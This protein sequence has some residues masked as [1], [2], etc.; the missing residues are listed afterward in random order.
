[1]DNVAVPHWTA[2]PLY[3]AAKNAA[4][5][6]TITQVDFARNISHPWMAPR[7]FYGQ[8]TNYAVRD[9]DTCSI[10]DGS[11][12][13]CGHATLAAVAETTPL[14]EMFDLYRYETAVPAQYAA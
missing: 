13:N 7:S 10:I 9:A 4:M 5:T 2:K 8:P 1:I 6:L 3:F 12:T 11:D 14:C